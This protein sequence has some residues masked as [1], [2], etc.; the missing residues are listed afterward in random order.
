[1]A[2]TV[3]KAERKVAKALAAFKSAHDTIAAA[4]AELDNEAALVDEQIASLTSYRS[5]VE[6]SKA[7]AAL[8]RTKLAEFII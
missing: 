3:T 1:M 4:E 8:V 5:S 2:D 6:T 7:N